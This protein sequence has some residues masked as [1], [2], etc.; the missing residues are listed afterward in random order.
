MPKEATKATHRQVMTQR[1]RNRGQAA[2]LGHMGA[3]LAHMEA[4][5]MIEP[6]IDRAAVTNP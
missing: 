1:K 6:D 4:V 3:M 5:T 2:G